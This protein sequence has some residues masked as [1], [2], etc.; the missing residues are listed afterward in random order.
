LNLFVHN[1]RRLFLVSTKNWWCTLLKCF[2][3]LS[4]E[5]CTITLF[6]TSC[7]LCHVMCS[8]IFDDMNN[9]YILCMIGNYISFFCVWQESFPCQ[10]WVC[11]ENAHI[12]CTW[13]TLYFQGST[14]CRSLDT[15]Q[16]SSISYRGVSSWT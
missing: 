10:S 1:P 14:T 3:A 4:S 7:D 13:S 9:F 5:W 16:F 6:T 11:F 12:F 15:C 2:R 8:T